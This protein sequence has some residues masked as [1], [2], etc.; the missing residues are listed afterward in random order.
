MAAGAALAGQRCRPGNH[1]PGARA[2]GPGLRGA[3]AGGRVRRQH[4]AVRRRPCGRRAAGG[5]AVALGLG[6]GGV[7]HAGHGLHRGA[8]VAHGALRGRRRRSGRERAGQGRAVGHQRQAEPAFP[9]QHA[10][11]LDRPDPQG[12][13][14]RRGGA[15]EVRVHAALCAG[16]Q[17]RHRRPG[18]AGRRDRVPARLPGA[19]SP[20]PGPAAARGLAAG[21]ARA[22]RRAAAADVAAAG[23]ELHPARGCA[24]QGRRLRDDLGAAQFPQ[25]RPGPGR[26]RRRPGLRARGAGAPTGAA[27]RHRPGGAEEALCARLRRPGPAAHPYR[28][29]RRIPRRLVHPAGMRPHP[30]RFA[31]PLQGAEPGHKPSCGLFVPGEG[32]GLRPW[33]RPV[34]RQSRCHG[35]HSATSSTPCADPATNPRSNLA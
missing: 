4:G 22:G 1:R 2:G 21:G 35:S 30:K 23:R 11:H 15:A 18:D 29:R 20:A 16:H 25:P 27:P 13:G 5:P 6:P 9:V 24:T 12:P 3:V 7:C 31:R 26:G 33:Q 32:R 19:G 14:R 34:A 17:A 28:S 8:A 10:E